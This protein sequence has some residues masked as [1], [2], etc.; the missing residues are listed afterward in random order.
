MNDIIEEFKLV[1]L[2]NLP[3]KKEELLWIINHLT[4]ILE[5]PQ[6]EEIQFFQ[7]IS[8]EYPEMIYHLYIMIN[9]ITKLDKQLLFHY[10]LDQ[11]LMK[12][13]SYVKI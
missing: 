9:T 6:K 12:L 7:D 10:M 3:N 2:E 13:M 5:I 11:S 4:N 8:E 1:I